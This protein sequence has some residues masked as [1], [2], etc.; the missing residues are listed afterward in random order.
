MEHNVDVNGL[1]TGIIYGTLV[2][3]LMPLG[4]AFSS[5]SHHD[6]NTRS[7]DIA[8]LALSSTL[9]MPCP[10]TTSRIVY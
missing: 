4:C 1:I 3:G 8:A 10:H 6:A 2:L 7:S 9:A 5:N